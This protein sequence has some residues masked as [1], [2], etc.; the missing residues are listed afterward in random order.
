MVS[1][2]GFPAAERLLCDLCDLAVMSPLRHK[3]TIFLKLL[4]NRL[5]T[6][7]LAH[8]QEEL[9][10]LVKKEHTRIDGMDKGG[11]SKGAPAKASSASA[12]PPHKKEQE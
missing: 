10:E 12:A 2:G 8:L 4:F 9:E 3:S 1:F 6:V 5:L 7:C 11:G